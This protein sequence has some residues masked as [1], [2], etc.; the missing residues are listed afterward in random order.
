MYKND[1]DEVLENID[2]LDSVEAVDD[3]IS[4]NSIKNINGTW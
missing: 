4:E 3:F 1:L 2:R